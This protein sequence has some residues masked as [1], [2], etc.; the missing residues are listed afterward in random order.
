VTGRKGRGFLLESINKLNQHIDT[1]SKFVV[2]EIEK[3]EHVLTIIAMFKIRSEV[4]WV[5]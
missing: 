3:M 4:G 1:D 5:E 2:D